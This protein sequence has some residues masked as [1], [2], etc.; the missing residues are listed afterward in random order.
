M[1][2]HRCSVTL[3]HL[4]LLLLFCSALLGCGKPEPPPVATFKT[5]GRVTYNNGDPVAGAIVQF[6]SAKN[7]SLN[8]SAQT[9]AD[10]TFVLV[11]LFGNEN[12]DGAIE[13]RCNAMITLP[14]TS[15]I[16]QTIAMPKPYDITMGDNHFDIQLKVKAP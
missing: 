3:C 4:L 1:R 7:S 10:G 11:T 16:P 5:T 14:I 8:M 13:G 2:R 9:D 15:P 12:L 6:I